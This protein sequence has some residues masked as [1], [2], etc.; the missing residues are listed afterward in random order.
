MEQERALNPQISPAVPPRGT[1]EPYKSEVGGGTSARRWS[2]EK[3]DE[4]ADAAALGSGYGVIEYRLLARRYT[5]LT[6]PN[7]NFPTNRIIHLRL[8]RRNPV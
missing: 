5:R 8:L 1:Q 6:T 2:D 3:A 4:K 7:L